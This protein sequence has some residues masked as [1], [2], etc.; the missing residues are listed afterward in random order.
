MESGQEVNVGET[1]NSGL[2]TEC[3]SKL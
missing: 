1:K 3:R 2:I